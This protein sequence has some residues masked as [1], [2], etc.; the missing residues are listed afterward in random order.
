MATKKSKKAT[1]KEVK[2]TVVVAEPSVKVVRKEKSSKN[3]SSENLLKVFTTEFTNFK[4]IAQLVAELIGTFLLTSVVIATQGQPIGVFFGILACVL[5]VG[6][7]SGAHINPAITAGAWATRKIR[8]IHALG[9]ILAQVLGAM[10]A[11]TVISAFIG[12]APAVDQQAQLMGQQAPKIFTANPIPEGKE[13]LALAAEVLG[14][15]IFAFGVA[16]VAK[17]KEDSAVALGVAGSLFVAILLAGSTAAIINAS[18]IFNPAIALALQAFTVEKTS[19]IWAIAVYLG[20][21]LAGGII[22][23]ALESLLDKASQK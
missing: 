13:A 2:S 14:M 23:F 5:I 15:A 21:A 4:F 16:N 10:L 9:Y 11:F 17:K 3:Y 8:T 19:H 12:A 20:G 1:S 6:K 18:A 7:I 22:G